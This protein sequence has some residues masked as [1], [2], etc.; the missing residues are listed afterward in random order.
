MFQTRITRL[1]GIKYPI[2]QGGMHWVARAQLAS[3]VSNA[4]GLGI[5]ASLTQPTANDLVAEIR[6]MRELTDQPFGVN[7][8]FI[9]TLRPINYD[10]YIDTII[11]EGVKIVETA[12]RNPEPY[13]P[14]LKAAGI[15]VI[16][17]CT[18]VRHAKTAE[19]IGCDALTVEGFEC[20]GHPGEDDV[21][22]LV[23]I[24][25]VVNTVKVPVI[26]SGGF[27]DARGFV[28][29]LALGAEGLNVG[30]RFFAS[31]EAPAHPKVKEWLLRACE[32]DTMLVMRSLRNSE[33]VLR[34]AFAERVAE[35]EKRGAPLEEL[36]PLISGQRGKQLLETGDLEYG[37]Q[38]A[39]QAVGLVHDI[40]P[41][42]DIIESI[43][44]GA[45]EIIQRL[46][47]LAG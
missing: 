47:K 22:S 26:A 10:E 13:M 9:P 35:M 15:K 23:L 34:S 5:I 30:T 40:L 41:V 21:T 14:R 3:A 7:V 33:R 18:S 8:T 12:G 2:I 38:T 24:P 19:A 29:A 39:S 37:L 20:A 16:H 45:Q 17:K 6:K 43:V 42:K 32:K 4:G 1:L 27:A 11:R 46:D 44:S 28:A 36:A 25:I 31:Q